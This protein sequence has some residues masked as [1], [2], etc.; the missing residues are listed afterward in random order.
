MSFENK[1]PFKIP[2]KIP[3][4]FLNGHKF[5]LP[6]KKITVPE[7]VEKFKKTKTLVNYMNFI[8]LWQ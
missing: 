4:E 2:F 8:Q 3:E 7:D 5:E 1:I 6:T